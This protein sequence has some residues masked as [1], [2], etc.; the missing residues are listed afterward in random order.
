[1]RFLEIINVNLLE[2]LPSFMQEYREIRRIMQSEEPEFKILWNLFKK[3]FNN[4]FI[5]YCDEDGISKFE[6]MLGLHRY[7]NDTLEIRIFRVLTYWNDQI[8]YTWRVLVNRMDQ[9]C[10]AGNYELR[11]NFNAYELRIT[12][13]FDDA[14]KYD[15]LNSMLKTILP[16]NLGFNSIN[17]LTPKTENRIYI[18]NG[19]INYM[20]YEIRAKLP[21]AVF[22]IFAT[23]GFIY[24]KKYVIGG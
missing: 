15:E 2:Y 6:G 20:K 24:S 12:T 18:T 8:P 7:E 16:A 17:I 3:V 21:D 11:P 22:K 1:M 4:Q 5:Q 9:L 13:K 14:K 10:G 23:S 19:V